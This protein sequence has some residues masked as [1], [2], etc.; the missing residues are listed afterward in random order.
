MEARSRWLAQWLSY[1]T[2]AFLLA[3]LLV[4]K[5]FI[6]NDF[7]YVGMLAPAVFSIRWRDL[8]N[9]HSEPLVNAFYLLLVYLAVSSFWSTEPDFLRYLKRLL[10]LYGLGLGCYLLAQRHQ[11]HEDRIIRWWALILALSAVGAAV[12]FYRDHPFPEERMVGIGRLYSPIYIPTVVLAYVAAAML[13]WKCLERTW[14]C[15][16]S[17]ALVVGCALIYLC[18][19]RSALL[20][21]MC[22]AI[23]FALLALRRQVVL[24]GLALSIVAGLALVFSPELLMERGTSFRIVIWQAALENFS[25]CHFLIGCGIGSES[26]TTWNGWYFPHQHSIFLGWLFYSGAIGLAGYLVFIGA[27]LFRLRQLHEYRWILILGMGLGVSLTAA[28]HL[29]I[30][31]NHNWLLLHIPFAMALAKLALARQART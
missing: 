5:S 29:L 21:L 22:V 20:A 19:S 12:Y 13:D 1:G 23:I 24:P 31:P 6:V 18:Q 3:F 30:T 9:Y 15:V 16:L 25:H 7:F 26:G 17:G 27:L 2:L 4:D 8:R 10:Y 28:N 11:R 14:R